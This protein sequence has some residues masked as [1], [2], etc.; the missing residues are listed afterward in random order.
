M[1]KVKRI[2]IAASL[3]ALSQYSI[4]GNVISFPFISSVPNISVGA[5]AGS[6]DQRG[7]DASGINQETG[8][9]HDARGFNVNGI[10]QTTGSDY[11]AEGFDVAG[12]N[13]DTGTQ[14]DS[15][16][17]DE[18]GHDAS[19]YSKYVCAYIAGGSQGIIKYAVLANNDFSQFYFYWDEVLL[20]SS[21]GKALTTEDG[22][23]YST[24][25]RGS[26]GVT[27]YIC[28]STLK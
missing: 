24:G 8:T 14:Y 28:R 21:S 7:F 15:E 9:Q 18:S 16:G 26:W 27:Y 1:F 2:F 20:G 23:R 6:I 12:N 11:N 19:G 5:T 4:A 22:T 17:F 25:A 13:A 3:M 10:H